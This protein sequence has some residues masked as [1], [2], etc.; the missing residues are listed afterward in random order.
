[1]QFIFILFYLFNFAFTSISEDIK[2]LDNLKNHFAEHPDFESYTG[3]IKNLQLLDE[4]KDDVQ[5]LIEKI[6]EDKIK[7][8]K[9]LSYRLLTMVN[10]EVPANQKSE[11]LQ[12]NP[13][14]SDKMSLDRL[15]EYLKGLQN[16]TNK[17]ESEN[18]ED[19]KVYD[20]IIKNYIGFWDLF[21]KNAANLAKK[22][23]LCM[24]NYTKNWKN[25]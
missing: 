24:L 8:I 18:Q 11:K 22:T 5:K 23:N 25:I 1:M 13:P 10:S 2:A 12:E 17:N 15:K 14:E 9:K 20:E 4:K 19:V 16:E 3:M 21:V 6:G 7:E